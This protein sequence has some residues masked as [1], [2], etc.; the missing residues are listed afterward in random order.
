M[1]SKMSIFKMLGLTIVLVSAIIAGGMTDAYAGV[2]V[3]VNLN[4]GPAP[5]EVVMVPSGVYFVPNLSLDVFFYSGFWWANRDNHWYRSRD[6]NGNWGEVNRRR[7]PASVNH[8]YGVPNYREVYGSHEGR[9]IPYGQWKKNEHRG[10][11]QEKHRGNNDHGDH[12]NWNKKDGKREKGG[13][14]GRGK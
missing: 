12:G 14:R 1:L 11:A 6:Y 7:V 13:K 4:L 5:Q 8:V 9:H 10:F 3:N 2:D